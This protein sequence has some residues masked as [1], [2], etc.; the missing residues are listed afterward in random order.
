[1]PVAIVPVIAWGWIDIPGA[2]VA[3]R[4]ARNRIFLGVGWKAVIRRLMIARQ[5]AIA[6]PAWR[7]PVMS[8]RSLSDDRQQRQDDSNRQKHQAR[9]SHTIDGR[10][11]GGDSNLS[12]QSSATVSGSLAKPPLCAGSGRSFVAY[13]TPQ[14]AIRYAKP[15]PLEF[16]ISALVTMVVVVDPLRWCRT[17]S[18]FSALSTARSLTQFARQTPIRPKAL[19]ARMC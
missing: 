10:P 9:H 3:P 16:L 14:T 17:N 2:P 7:R 5:E 15:M 11:S 12:A 8:G 6:V 1:V 19:S 13:L 18:K 4:A